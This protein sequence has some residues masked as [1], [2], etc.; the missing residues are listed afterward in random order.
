LTEPDAAIHVAPRVKRRI[1][2]CAH[3]HRTLIPAKLPSAMKKK[4]G[5]VMAVRV[6]KF[7]YAVA[8]LM[9][10]MFLLFFWLH[11]QKTGLWI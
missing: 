8:F 10:L 5:A 2:F 7:F 6:P 9:A 1:G 11:H 4:T 3:P